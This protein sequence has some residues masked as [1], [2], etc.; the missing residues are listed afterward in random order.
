MISNSVRERRCCIAAAVVETTTMWIHVWPQLQR[1][2]PHCPQE[3]IRALRLIQW[4]LPIRDRD[5]NQATPP[6]IPRISTLT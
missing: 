4:L 3:R 6:V 1:V 5:S 2:V